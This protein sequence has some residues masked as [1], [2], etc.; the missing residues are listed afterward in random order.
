M[1]CRDQ[2]SIA[3]SIY[4]SFD[5]ITVKMEVDLSFCLYR[6]VASTNMNAVSSRSHAVFTIILTQK[7]YDEMTKLT[8][9]KVTRHNVPM[10]PVIVVI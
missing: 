6:T 2:L 9:E 3:H 7:L 5:V 1:T 4:N 8:T 10:C